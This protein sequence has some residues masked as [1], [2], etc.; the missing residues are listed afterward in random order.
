MENPWLVGEYFNV[1]MDAAEKLGGLPITHNKIVDLH[2]SNITWWNGRIEGEYLFKRLDMIFGNMKFM[3]ELPMLEV[4]HLIKEG[5]DH[6]TLQVECNI[7]QER[8]SKPFRLLNFWSKQERFYKVVKE[9]WQIEV[10]ECPFHI[11][12]EKMKNLKKVL[13]K[14]SKETYGNIF[15]KVATLEDVVKVK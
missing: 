4:K 5:S 8:V 13:T 2:S 3:Q 6:C 10:Q 14:W 15:H 7:N 9:N 12:H 11:V 1:I